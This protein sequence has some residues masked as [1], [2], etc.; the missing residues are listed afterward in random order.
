MRITN[1]FDSMHSECISLGE[2]ASFTL[3]EIHLI[4]CI[5]KHKESNVTE[6][7]TILGNTK[8]AVSQMAKKLENKG[9]L[10]KAK[11][12]ENNKEVF[13]V[14]TPDG[15]QL[16]A[17]HEKLHADLYDDISQKMN[18]SSEENIANMREILNLVERYMREYR[19]K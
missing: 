16:F 13:L 2:N 17:A 10:V 9:M 12:G 8:G 1:Q 7:A 11:K 14:L 3:S 4:D 5:G 19:K 6:I 15:E 18:Q